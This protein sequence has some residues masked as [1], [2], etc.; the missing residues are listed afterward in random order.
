MMRNE[1]ASFLYCLTYN[2]FL[3]LTKDRKRVVYENSNCRIRKWRSYGKA[4]D[5]VS[6]GHD[7]KLY[8]RNQSISKFQN[9]IEKG[10]FDFNNEGDERFVKF[11]D[12]SDDMEYVLKDAE[13]VQVIIPSSYIEYYADVMAEHVTDNQLIF[14]NMVI[15]NGVNSFYECFR[16]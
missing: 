15:K 5:M 10:G 9:A 11:T 8:C 6:K 14:F 16:R 13:I 7:V 12:I 1:F 2:L 4:V 3:I